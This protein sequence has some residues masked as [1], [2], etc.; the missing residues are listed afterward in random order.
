VRRNPAYHGAVPAELTIEELAAESGMTV[1][2]IRAHQARGLIAPPEV[3]MRVGYY[4]PEHVA[5]LRLIRE[6][7]ADGF[8]LAAIHRLLSDRER[9][10]ERFA[11]FRASLTRPVEEERPQTYNAADLRE[12]LGV[13]GAEATHVLAR[14]EQLGAIVSA[15]DGSYLAPSP[16]LLALA[17]QAV[18]SGIS[19]SGAIEVFERTQE[20]VDAIA[21]A[22]VRLFVTDVWRGFEQ[23]G[24]P[25]ERWP[26]VDEAIDR[27]RRLATAAMAAAFAQRLNGRIDDA[28]AGD[29]EHTGAPAIDG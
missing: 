23:E 19:I 13:S 28:F 4:G 3:R 29:R 8:N 10:E 16:S 18:A 24:M 17:E 7:Q 15:A 12:R 25:D 27:L 11:Q 2:N 22:F 5:A 26:E 21:A 1:R 14:A 9:T 20:H 6:L